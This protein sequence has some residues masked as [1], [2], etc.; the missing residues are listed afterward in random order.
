MNER[1]NE[2]M[3]PYFDKMNGIEEDV[4]Q[5]REKISDVLNRRRLEKR[6]LELRLERLRKNKDKEIN[7]YIESQPMLYVGYGATLRKDLE[8]MYKSQEEEL[9]AEIK[10]FDIVTQKQIDELEKEL[11]NQ[12]NRHREE[13]KIDMSYAKD[14]LNEFNESNRAMKDAK[15][16]LNS[17]ISLS[18]M[19]EIKVNT[20]RQL[21]SMQK[22]LSL[23]LDQEEINFQQVMLKINRFE[24]KYDDNHQ[25]INADEWKKLYEESNSIKAKCEEIRACLEKIKQNLALMELTKEEAEYLMRSKAPFEERELSERPA[26]GV[27]LSDKVSDDTSEAKKDEEINISDTIEDEE[28]DKT[29]DLPDMIEEKETP[30]LVNYEKDKKGNITVETQDDLLKALYNEILKEIENLRTVR[31]N[32]S[33]GKLGQNGRYVNAK[34]DINSSYSNIGNIVPSDDE[35]IQLPNGEYLYT[36]DFNQAIDRLY[37][38]QKGR[39]YKVKES[40]KKY[41]ITYRTLNK[42]KSQLKDSAI[43][44]LKSKK[45]SEGKLLYGGPSNKDQVQLGEVGPTNL[46]DGSYLLK[47]DVIDKLNSVF[48]PSRLSSLKA[49]ISKLKQ[50]NR[51]DKTSETQDEIEE[52]NENKS[53]EKQEELE[54]LKENK[55]KLE[56]LKKLIDKLKQKD[57][58]E[59]INDEGKE[60]ELNL[61]DAY[62]I[63]E[64][65][66]TSNASKDIIFPPDEQSHYEPPEISDKIYALSPEP[67]RYEQ[68]DLSGQIATLKPDAEPISYEQ[69]DLSGQFATL[70]S[71]EERAK[72]R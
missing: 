68:H 69:P 5:N 40:G 66:D 8:E 9:L 32:G 33:N 63:V 72:T 46:P 45:D 30:V 13:Y 31:I 62:E 36:S 43:L 25:I 60:A 28:N 24:Y 57:N 22:E 26:N 58:K 37:N 55:N 49:F 53:S 56:L 21:I 29:D 67:T 47:N 50:K 18:E 39:T 14:L 10:S 70:D 20:K 3:K 1:L 15:N 4:K 61:N 65:N 16:A 17:N 48:T 27:D 2:I 64:K 71:Y 59:K 38:K 42:F 44:S 11:N 51:K 19:V 7:E 41:K 54:E 23:Q 52:F 35:P 34:D 12:Q 6:Q